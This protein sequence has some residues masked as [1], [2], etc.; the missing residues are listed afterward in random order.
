ISRRT[1]RS[2]LF[3]YTT[4]FRSA[5]RVKTLSVR[6]DRAITL[7]VEHSRA[8]LDHHE[9]L[10]KSLSYQAV[11]DRGF[12]LVRDSNDTPLKRAADI[13]SGQVLHLQFADGTA[14]AIATSQA[15]GPKPAPAQTGKSAPAPKEKGGQG[16]LF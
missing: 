6:A 1:S 2:T 14:D 5:E 13:A 3:P 8:K 12:A 9:R 4:L 15:A 10:A 11:L 16:S 7:R